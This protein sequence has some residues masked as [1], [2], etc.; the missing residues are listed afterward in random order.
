MTLVSAREA[1]AYL[2]RLIDRAIAGEEIIITRKGRRVVRL[3]P[4]EHEAQPAKAGKRPLGLLK[5][6]FEIPATFYDPLPEEFL[7]A[8]YDGPIL[9]PGGEE[10]GT[11]P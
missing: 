9:P 10:D 8:F 4:V 1:R 2:S 6:A 3:A 11:Q 7:D 5:G